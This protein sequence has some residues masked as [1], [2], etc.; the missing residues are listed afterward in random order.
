MFKKR[1]TKKFYLTQE[2]LTGSLSGFC[3]QPL[4]DF[5]VDDVIVLSRDVTGLNCDVIVL[6]RDVIALSCNVTGL[7]CDVTVLSCDVTG[8]D[9]CLVGFD[10]GVYLVPLH[11]GG[12]GESVVE[13]N[14][15]GLICVR[16]NRTLKFRFFARNCRMIKYFKI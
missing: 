4:N 5:V 8:L 7:N 9:P 11:Q 16:A 6:S 1:K 14:C 12:V 3:A 2:I 15:S 10:D 13:P